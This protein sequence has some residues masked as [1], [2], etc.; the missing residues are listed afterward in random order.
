MYR[1][2]Q[3]Q[4]ILIDIREK[5]AREADFDMDLFLQQ[6]RES[7]ECRIDIEPEQ[8]RRPH[9]RAERGRSV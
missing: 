2:P 8:G 9:V 1:R 5:M 4:K 6:I 3:F 7:G